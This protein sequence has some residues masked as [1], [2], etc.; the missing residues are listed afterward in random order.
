MSAGFLLTTFGARRGFERWGD[1]LLAHGAWALAAGQLL[2]AAQIGL[3]EPLWALLPAL[4]FT[5]GAFGV[6]MSPLV[7]RAVGAVPLAKAGIAGGVVGSVQWLGNALGV[8][9]IG[10]VYFALA[11]RSAADAAVISHVM[12]AALAAGVAVLLRRW[13][14]AKGTEGTP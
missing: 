9:L 2:I 3:R 10:S 4:L 14:G 7:A 8:A 1:R 12:L 6:V 5:G 11:Q 13:L